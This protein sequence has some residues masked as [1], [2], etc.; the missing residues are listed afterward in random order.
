MPK[1]DYKVVHLYMDAIKV[2]DSLNEYGEEGW[3]L[4]TVDF[5]SRRYIFKRIRYHKINK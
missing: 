3:E 4:I 2:Q 1:F 5:E